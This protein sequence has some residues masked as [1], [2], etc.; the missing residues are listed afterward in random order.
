MTK[1]LKKTARKKEIDQNQVLIAPAFMSQIPV[2][3]MLIHVDA[4][5]VAVAANDMSLYSGLG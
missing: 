5:Q 1:K 3:V 4:I 2:G